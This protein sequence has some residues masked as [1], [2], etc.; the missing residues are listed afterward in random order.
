MPGLPYYDK[1]CAASL[2]FTRDLDVSFYSG[3]IIHVHAKYY[4]YNI[5]VV[6]AHF[7]DIKTATCYT[8]IHKK[9]A[10]A[11]TLDIKKWKHKKYF[12][13]SSY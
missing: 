5:S 7:W 11:G 12:F 10:S 3:N 8:V 13:L 2:T 9:Q 1:V 6:Q 4:Y